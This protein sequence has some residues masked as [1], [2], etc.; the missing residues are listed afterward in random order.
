MRWRRP[1]R[2][3][4]F[5]TVGAASVGALAGC[6]TDEGELPAPITIDADHNCPVCN[7]VIVNHPGP[8]GHAFYPDDADIPDQDV[9]DGVVPYC[10]STCAYEYVFEY[11]EYGEDPRVIYL[12]DYSKVDWEIYRD[13]DVKYITAHFEADVHTDARDLTFAV[14]S[15][16]L[17]A[18]GQSVIGFSDPEDAESFAEE[19]GGDIYDHDSITRELIDSL[20]FV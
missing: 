5:L 20:G 11:E 9:Q 7:M 16:V 12:T 17:G 3:S 14:D 6:L 15:E 10:A 4:L 19:Y 8:A 1:T 2:R 13:G 18:M